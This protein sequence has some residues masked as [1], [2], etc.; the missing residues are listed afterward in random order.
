TRRGGGGALRLLYWQAPTILN[1]H[2]NTG[3]KDLHA[4]RLFYEPLAHF[5]REGNLIPI[6]AADVP[7]LQNGGVAMD[8]GHEPRDMMKGGG[9]R[10]IGPRGRGGRFCFCLGVPRHPPHPPQPPTG[11]SVIS[12]VLTKFTITR[13]GSSLRNRPPFGRNRPF[14]TLFH[15]TSSNLTAER[16]R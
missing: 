4:A 2:L 13:F 14:P 5:D 15:G 16:A 7:N 10:S 1:P 6:L 3:T 9:G 11:R 12:S 8:V